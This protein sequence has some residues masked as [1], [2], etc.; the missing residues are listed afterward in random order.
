LLTGIFYIEPKTPSFVDT[1]Q[2]TDTPLAQL[3]AAQTRPSRAALA[4]LMA[5][6]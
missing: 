3:S 2:I 1:L 6:L 5:K 4:Q